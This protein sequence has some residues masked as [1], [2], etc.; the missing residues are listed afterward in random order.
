MPTI[1]VVIQAVM[2][3]YAWG[4]TTDIMVDS[5][6]GMIHMMPIYKGYALR[7]AILCMDLGSQDL[8][9]YLMKILTLSNL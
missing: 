8:T 1:C 5:D 6:N 3:L 2:L 9:G 7:Y 4:H